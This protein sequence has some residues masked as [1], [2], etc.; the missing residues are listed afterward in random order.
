MQDLIEDN[1]K[2][3]DAMRPEDK[4]KDWH[5][6]IYRG[7]LFTTI[8]AFTSWQPFLCW[9]LTSQ[10]KWVRCLEAQD[11][12]FGRSDDVVQTIEPQRR[13]LM[14]Q[15]VFKLVNQR[16]YYA[17]RVVNKIRCLCRSVYS[18][19]TPIKNLDNLVNRLLNPKD[20]LHS[21]V[22][23]LLM[24]KYLRRYA[25]KWNLNSRWISATDTLARNG[26]LRAL[27]L[28]RAYCRDKKNQNW[29][30][31]LKEARHSLNNRRWAKS[32][33]LTSLGSWHR[34]TSGQYPQKKSTDGFASVYQQE[35]TPLND[36]LCRRI[37]PRL[38]DTEDR[39][40]KIKELLHVP[41]FVSTE[42]Q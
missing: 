32:R 22:Q 30:R 29:K 8:F 27:K 28:L 31:L 42:D 5:A 38:T 9:S 11:L 19:P 36:L 3:A 14:I 2:I 34:N 17:V 18:P 33:N 39:D 15:Q 35:V 12:A 13:M 23:C 7:N 4:V 24:Q 6:A 16:A 10:D 40:T 20:Y 26:H 41:F 1:K 21:A 37:P 25:A